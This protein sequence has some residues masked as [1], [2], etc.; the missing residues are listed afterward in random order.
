M[1]N[2]ARSRAQARARA[3]CAALAVPLALLVGGG[4]AAAETATEHTLRQ[5]LEATKAELATTK[6]ELGETRR[7]LSDLSQRVDAIQGSVAPSPAA[8][9]GATTRL[10]PVNADNPAIS[11]VVDTRGFSNTEGGGAGFDLA[12]GEL[13]ISAPIDPFLRGY[14]SI[15]GTSGEG[16]DLEEAALITTALPGN[17]T[18]KGGRFFADV[19]R[20]PHWHDEALPFAYRPLSIDRLIGG[21][22]RAEGAEVTWLAPTETFLQIHGGV[23]NEIGEPEGVTSEGPFGNQSWSQLTYLAHPSTYFELTDRA[24]LE[25]GGTWFQ[26][27]HDTDR[28]V[29]G[30]DVTFRDQPGTGE[31]YNGTTVGAEW[32][33]S[34]ARGQDAN[35][36]LD[37]ATGQPAFD[38]N[39]NEV[40][41]HSVFTRVGGYG[42][43]ETFF[44]RR[45]SA[46]AVFDYSQAPAGA[47]DL[48]KTYSAFLTWMPSEFQRLRAQIDQIVETGNQN[49]QRFTIQWTAFIGSHSHGFTS[50]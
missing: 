36:L 48:T 17:L 21:E 42:Y 35:P 45:F 3:S 5:E 26:Q 41:G 23:Y 32:Y 29:L 46:G 22:S 12:N 8:A 10:A 7:A 47:A 31:V 44:A 16:F 39:G 24:S 33:W 28:R 27:P 9:A 50:H 6:Q 49:D 34:K 1:S 19:G 40:F 43:F 37:P 30:V 11:F 2:S 15:N 25:L 13:F 14:A 20:F 18:V 4:H 38:A